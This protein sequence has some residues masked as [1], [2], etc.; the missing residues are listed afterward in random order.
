MCIFHIN[1]E[2]FLP[3][4]KDAV[5]DVFTERNCRKA[6]EASGL[7]SLDVQVV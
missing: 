1:K 3:A 5:F 4:F 7:V 6:I 2:G